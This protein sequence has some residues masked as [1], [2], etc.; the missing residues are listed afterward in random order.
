[1]SNTRRFGIITDVYDGSA[2]AII[3]N[4]THEI[5]QRGIVASDGK[6]A[7]T[8]AKHTRD[9]LNEQETTAKARNG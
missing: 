5:V 6:T 9:F 7:W 1:M 8:N 3:D 2:L 4:E